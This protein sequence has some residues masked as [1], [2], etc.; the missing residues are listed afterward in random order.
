MEI[1]KVQLPHVNFVNHESSNREKNYSVDTYYWQH[2]YCWLYLW[3][4]TKFPTRGNRDSMGFIS[5]HSIIRLM[6]ME[7]PFGEK[8]GQE[9]KCCNEQQTPNNLIFVALENLSPML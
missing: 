1:K 6:V 7:R 4:R 9:E 3:T 8:V 5:A 2:T